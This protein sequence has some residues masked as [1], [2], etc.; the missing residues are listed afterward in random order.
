MSRPAQY[1]REDALR[2]AMLIFW[3]KGYHATSLKDLEAGL[4]MKPGSIYTAFCSKENLYLLALDLYVGQSLARFAAH[5]A[6][7]R[8]PLAGLAEHLRGFARL[9]PQ[10]AARQV[11]MLTK[12]L[13]DTTSTEPNI[14]KHAKTHLRQIRHAFETGFARA[15]AAGELPQSADCAHLA[16]RFQ[17]AVAALRFELHL[18]TEQPEIAALADDLA[19]EFEALRR[20]RAD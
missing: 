12:T 4:E 1:D 20:A 2:R 19:R 17:G 16:R 6:A 9:A 3:E 11:C 7:A 15:K 13:V 14:A 10:D 5:M 8:S 18:G